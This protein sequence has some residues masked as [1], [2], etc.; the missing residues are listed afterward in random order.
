[1]LRARR[2]LTYANVV[3]TLALVIAL[4]AGTAF[5]AGKINGK[6]IRKGTITGNK[7]KRD[8][9]TGAQI[10]ESSLDK[11][12]SAIRAD[13]ATE[14]DRAG[15]ALNAVEADHIG[16]L[17]AAQIQRV[18][19]VVPI[20]TR[21]A[22]G[23]TDRTLV[24]AG[25]FTVKGHCEAGGGGQS[26]YQV[27]ATTTENNSVEASIDVFDFKRHELDFDAGDNIVITQDQE[28][29]TPPSP[30]I[31]FPVTAYLLSPGGTAIA[32][33]LAQGGHL[34]SNNQVQCTYA[35]FAVVA[36]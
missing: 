31:L 30:S 16:G 2:H 8:T 34:F 10:S 5:A 1:M 21:M 9:L 35:G 14:A 3:A 6:S 22:N 13:H 17:T 28:S 29:G 20:D 27:S 11:V 18:G 23:E 15:T 25:P 32:I 4:G 33:E 36:G 26:F 7:L 24:Q 19:T 12:P